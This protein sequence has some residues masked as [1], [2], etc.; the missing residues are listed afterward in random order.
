M[1]A[2]AQDQLLSQFCG[3]PEMCSVKERQIFK[4]TVQK[5][6]FRIIQFLVTKGTQYSFEFQINHISN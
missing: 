3:V 4:Q 1:L 2:D 6:T 5:I